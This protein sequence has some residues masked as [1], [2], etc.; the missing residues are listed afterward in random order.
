MLM[1][2]R[3]DDDNNNNGKEEKMANETATLTTAAENVWTRN[4]PHF[5]AQRLKKIAIY[6]WIVQI[7]FDLILA[8]MMTRITVEYDQLEWREN[9]K[10][11]S[12]KTDDGTLSAMENIIQLSKFH[13]SREN[14]LALPNK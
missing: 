13:L 10:N 4:R 2:I 3:N 8:S 14:R 9:I 7:L 1:R 6:I 11:N 5:T 12:A